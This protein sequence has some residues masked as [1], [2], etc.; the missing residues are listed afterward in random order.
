MDD[1]GP[2]DEDQLSTT[3]DEQYCLPAL[4]GTPYPAN[5][6]AP[7]GD[8]CPDP[9]STTYKPVVTPSPPTSDAVAATDA[10]TDAATA[11]EDVVDTPFLTPENAFPPS[12][13]LQ[14]NEPPALTLPAASTSWPAWAASGCS[15]PTTANPRNPMDEPDTSDEEADASDNGDDAESLMILLSGD[16]EEVDETG[17]GDTGD[18]K[19]EDLEEVGKEGS[20]EN[21]KE[22]METKEDA[23]EGLFAAPAAPTTSTSSE[24]ATTTSST[25][26]TAIQPA[27]LPAITQAT[28]ATSS[29]AAMTASTTL[30]DRFMTLPGVLHATPTRYQCACGKILLLNKKGSYSDAHYRDHERACVRHKPNYQPSISTVSGTLLGYPTVL[31]AVP[32]AFVCAICDKE[33]VVAKG[34]DVEGHA[35]HQKACKGKPEMNLERKKARG[36]RRKKKRAERREGRPRKSGEPKIGR[37]GPRK[38]AL[39]DCKNQHDTTKVVTPWARNNAASAPADTAIVCMPST[40]TARRVGLLDMGRIDGA[41]CEAMDAI[42]FAP[43]ATPGSA[44]LASTISRRA[45]TSSS[46]SGRFIITPGAAPDFY[47]SPMFGRGEHAGERGRCSMKGFVA[48]SG[49]TDALPAGLVTGE[50]G[51]DAINGVRGSGPDKPTIAAITVSMLPLPMTNPTAFTDLNRPHAIPRAH[52]PSRTRASKQPQRPI[53]APGHI[54]ARRQQ[55]ELDRQRLW[56]D[57]SVSSRPQVTPD[58]LYDNHTCDLC[59]APYSHALIPSPSP[60]PEHDH[61]RTL[62]FPQV[63]SL[64]AYIADVADLASNDCAASGALFDATEAAAMA[65]VDLRVDVDVE[66]LRR[67]VGEAREKMLEVVG[68]ATWLQD[69]TRGG[70]IEADGAKRAV[71]GA[72]EEGC[73]VAIGGGMMGPDIVAVHATEAATTMAVD[74]EA[75]TTSK[76]AMDDNAAVDPL[77]AAATVASE[78]PPPA[79]V[80]APSLVLTVSP[81]RARPIAVAGDPP[82]KNRK[83]STS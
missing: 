30:R 74:I 65:A 22:G 72:G 7:G 25:A 57:R 39:A 20:E 34:K 52:R 68:D 76:A 1:S 53:G 28:T 60:L 37:S 14:Q 5:S 26:A 49:G 70:M 67:L 35:K 66:G 63:P 51:G 16:E 12:S 54:E 40:K 19:A 58:S 77:L 8:T 82:A 10:A 78:S 31:D 43:T 32:G 83:I 75:V 4:L 41:A 79:F 29:L 2:H 73:M 59:P 81:K 38:K 62:Y 23:R 15:S 44:S 13:K 18:E 69:R 36:R 71:D 48:I 24:V 11:V 6:S 55:Q 50:V 27:T 56:R 46:T 42:R 21:G 9:L 3:E 47:G 17:G 61:L 45:S 33:V 64:P 80:P